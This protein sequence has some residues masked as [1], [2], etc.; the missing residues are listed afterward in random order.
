M[1]QEQMFPDDCDRLMSLDE[2]R[3]RL[4]TSP[5]TVARLVKSGMLITLRFGNFK[6]VRKNTFHEFLRR[7]DGQD[8]LEIL[9][10]AEK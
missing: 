4:H 6:R 8:L 2:V 3:V 7:Y 5:A 9:K 10:E 1:N